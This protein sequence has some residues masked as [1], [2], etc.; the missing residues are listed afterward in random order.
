MLGALQACVGPAAGIEA[1]AFIDNL[2]NLPDLDA[3]VRGES[4]P[5]PTE[6][7]LQYAVASALVAR[8]VRT[9]ANA[10]HAKTL[11]HILDYATGFPNREMSVMLVSDMQRAV[12]ERL[13]KVPQFAGWAKSVADVMLFDFRRTVAGKRA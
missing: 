3:I 11:G 12:G 7:D 6:I 2:S 8:A 13:F 1:K 10:D 5:V 9:E 4:A